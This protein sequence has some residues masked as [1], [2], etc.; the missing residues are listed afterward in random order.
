MGNILIAEDNKELSKVLVLYLNSEGYNVFVAE[1]G[2]KALEIF[3]E[4]DIDLCILDIMMPK[5]DGYEVITSIRDESDIPIFILSAKNEDNDKILGLNIGADDYITKPFNP[6]EVVARVNAAFRRI[7]R[8]GKLIT[9]IIEMEDLTLDLEKY[10]VLKNR[11]VVDMT[12]TE[13]KILKTLL[14]RPGQIYSKVKISEKVN[15]EYFESD[16]NTITVHISHIRDK[17]GKRKNGEEYIKT[18]RG[19]GYKIERK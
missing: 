6:L 14:E 10:Q 11:K 9:G 17:I 3:K 1:D 4:N 16:E 12:V 19:L 8:R 2:L 5:I 15:G 18:V 13:F 7:L